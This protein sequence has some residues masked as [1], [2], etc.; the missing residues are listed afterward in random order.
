MKNTTVF[1]ATTIT[2][3]LTACGGGETG[4]AEKAI[5]DKLTKDALCTTVPVGAQVNYEKVGSDGA[6]GLL[7]AKGYLVEA[8]AIVEGWRGKQ[9]VDSY[10]L[11]EKGKPLVHKD[12][13][14]NLFGG[15]PCL[16]TGH[17][18]IEKIIALDKGNDAAG[19]PVANVR[20]SIKF[21]PEEWIADTKQ[22]PAWS[23]FWKNVQDAES[24]QWLYQAIKSG[25]DFISVSHGEKLSK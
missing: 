15:G 9:E 17:F 3:L 20:A 23:A 7:K 14:A 19:R 24:S 6:I 1:L 18:E 2:C 10:E 11:T 13:R 5:N 21:I 25:D 16:R 4:K 22:T 12:G 8:K